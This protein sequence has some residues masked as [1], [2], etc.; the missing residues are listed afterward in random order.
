MLAINTINDY[1][2]LLP[3]QQK[4]ILDGVR[5]KSR[6]DRYL[7]S[8]NTRTKEESISEPCK[9]CEGTGVYTKEVR[10]DS[11]TDYHAS[12]ISS[13]IRKTYFD[14]SGY[15]DQAV[16]KNDAQ[17]YRT[18]DAGTAIHKVIQGYGKDG[19]FCEAQYYQDEVKIEPNRE[20]ALLK[21][22]HDLPIAQQY[23]F[24]SAV[25]GIIWHLV[26]DVTGI[27]PV[28]VR[29]VHEYKTIGEKGFD[30]LTGPK[31]EHRQQSIIYNM[32]FNIPIT[33]YLYWCLGNSEIKDFACAINFDDWRFVENRIATVEQFK[34]LK[35]P[36]PF[37]MSSAKLNS[38]ECAGAGRFTACKY[39]GNV[40]TP[41]K[42]L[43]SVTT[44]KVKKNGR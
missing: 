4:E 6:L 34:E 33:V 35:E 42:E 31:E 7:V 37:E 39:F 3:L 27:G 28:S 12:S 18:L 16:N 1:F 38:I 17:S 9:S 21:S 19:A 14:V 29:V 40:C 25:D 26:V 22:L 36:P 44:A 43:I 10:L 13:C 2:S 30:F 5:V 24:R 32:V 8:R 23:K 15:R 11:D 41:P 20:L